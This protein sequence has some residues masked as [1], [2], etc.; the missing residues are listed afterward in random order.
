MRQSQLFLSTLREVPADAEVASHQLLLRAGIARPLTA[1]VYTFLPLGLRVLQKIENIIRE[2]MDAAGA[3]EI[4]MPAVQMEELWEQSGRSEDYGSDMFR[5]QDRHNRRLVLGPTHEEVI[6]TLVRQEVH[7]YRQ[8]PVT[9]Y[10]IQTKYRDEARPRAGLIRMREFRMKDAYSFDVDEAG[11]DLSYKAMYDAYCRIFDRLGVAY[12]AV[13]ADPGAIGGDGGTHEF[14]VLSPAGEDTVAGCDTCNY[15]ANIEKASGQALSR[16]D[17]SGT[18]AKV[19]VATPGTKTIEDLVRLLN[20]EA[21]QIIKVVVYLADG[22]PVAVCLRGDH[23]VNEVK[24]KNLL[25]ARHV[26]IASAEEVLRHTGRPVGFVGP[27]VNLRVV[28]DRDIWSIADGVMACEEPGFHDIH[29][30][31]GRDFE[32]AETADIREV[33]E[34]D[35][36]V[37]CGGRLQFFKGIEVGHVFKLGKRYSEV[38]DASYLDETGEKRTIVMGC[39]GLGTTRVIAAIV[40]QCHDEQGIIWPIA[41]APYQVHI[42]PVSMRDEAQVKGAEVLYHRLRA[43]G[44]EV[45]LDDRDERPG[46]KFKDADLI[47]LPLRV[48]VG[49]KIGE[50]NVEVKFRHSGEVQILPMEQAFELVLSTVK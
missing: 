21:R 11:L 1:G 32:V 40:E 28:F 19:R 10:Q 7:S 31:P 42:V 38:F 18:P 8:L 43:A 3:Q 45:L 25:G 22:T 2:E 37:H 5:L 44:V 4:L 39:Y 33:V 6:T 13:D 47:G 9:L 49:N 50:G 48:T 20:V 12:R 35:T 26:E 27:D 24:L 16:A 30:V 23:E 34:G 29:V 17:A 46:V 36:C 15:A 41:V 14:M